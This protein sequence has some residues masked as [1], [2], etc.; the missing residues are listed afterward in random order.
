[1]GHRHLSWF[2]FTQKSKNA[3]KCLYFT[4]GGHDT[5]FKIT[6]KP[7]Y[8]CIMTRLYHTRHMLHHPAI[9]L[10]HLFMRYY[11]QMSPSHG[12][13]PPP[14]RPC[15]GLLRWMTYCWLAGSTWI[16]PW[17]LVLETPSLLRICERRET[18]MSNFA[19]D[20]LFLN[21]WE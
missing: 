21:P 4:A 11:L 1:M 12:Q 5:A 15:P 9:F 6:V 20:M 7:L 8:H 19:Q 13:K 16:H 2:H 3:D 10:S 18:Q 17:I 14:C